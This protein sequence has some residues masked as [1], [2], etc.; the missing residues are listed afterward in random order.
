MEE[1]PTRLCISN[2]KYD[3]RGSDTSGIYW[4]DG[5]EE[6]KLSKEMSEKILKSNRA[7]IEEV[8]K[9]AEKEAQELM[10]AFKALQEKHQK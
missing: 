6:K 1:S 4:L 7:I 10:T 9:E 2:E 3:L 8:R 5:I